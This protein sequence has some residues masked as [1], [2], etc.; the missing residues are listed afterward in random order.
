MEST[1]LQYTWWASSKKNKAAR[2]NI[3]AATVFLYLADLL[4]LT[5]MTKQLVINNVTLYQLGRIRKPRKKQTREREVSEF[6]GVQRIERR[7]H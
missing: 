7:R 2:G 3:L 6:R 4:P 5:R 1:D